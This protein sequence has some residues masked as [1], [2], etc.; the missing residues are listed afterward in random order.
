MVTYFWANVSFFSAM[1]GFSSD[2]SCS[3]LDK[4]GPF[5]ESEK[6]EDSSDEILCF[7]DGQ[8]CFRKKKRKVREFMKLCC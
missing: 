2:N 7:A 5:L 4:G 6:W 3:K 1:T 8:V